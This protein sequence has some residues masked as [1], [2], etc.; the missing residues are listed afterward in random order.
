MRASAIAASLRA[1]AAE[2]APVAVLAA[3]AVALCAGPWAL[4]GADALTLGRAAAVTFLAL[5]ALRAADDLRSVEADRTAHPKR[6][7]VTGRIA[8]GPL[9]AGAGFLAL[10]AMLIG[11]PRLAPWLAGLALYYAAY[12]AIA[13]HIPTVL[14]PVLVNAVFAA[15]PLGVGRLAGSVAWPTSTEAGAA[16]LEASGATALL[17]CALFFWLAS[18]GHD[19]AH[20]VH[21]PDEAPPGAPTVSSLMG[22]GR[23]AA[24]ALACYAAAAAAG[25]LV[26]LAGHKEALALAAAPAP[27]PRLFIAGLVIGFAGVG[28]LLARLVAEPCRERARRLYVSGFACFAGP[29]MLLGLDRLLGW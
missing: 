5:F 15:I 13:A 25:V 21:A 29:S 11:G 4:T 7:L 26:A 3:L 1:F 10:G 20:E 18:V 6:G 24:L 8:A 28:R 9:G 23:A 14:R 17:P 2:R 27:W 16:P 19:L 22:P 12:Y